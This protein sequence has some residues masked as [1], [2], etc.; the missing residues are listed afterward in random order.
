MTEESKNSIANN[1]S[2]I[3]DIIDLQR[4][5]Y[6]EKRNVKSARRR[7]L[8]EIIERHIHKAEKDNDS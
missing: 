1:Q 5:Y 2:V 7:N 8:S 3:R 6:F 4:R